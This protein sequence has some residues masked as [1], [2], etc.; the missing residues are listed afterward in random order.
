MAELG[1][2]PVDRLPQGST[3][4]ISLCIDAENPNSSVSGVFGFIFD[5]ERLA[6]HPVISARCERQPRIE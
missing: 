4:G 6:A 3:W 5:A 1:E 2:E